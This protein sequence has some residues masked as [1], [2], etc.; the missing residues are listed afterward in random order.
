MYLIFLNINI[1][2]HYT[3]FLF[4]L[5]PHSTRGHNSQPLISDLRK[6]P[7]NS[8]FL[9]GNTQPW[10]QQVM[11]I[12]RSGSQPYWIDVAI[13]V[14][15]IRHTDS[16]GHCSEEVTILHH[17]HRACKWHHSKLWLPASQVI[18]T[19]RKPFYVLLCC[20]DFSWTWCCL[21]SI[22]CAISM[23]M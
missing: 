10:V 12:Q 5:I 14:R 2:F 19:Q 15:V 6:R 9:L 11:S 17:P 20:L 1:T 7:L 8:E 4:I 16:T 18:D 22:K 21:L 23:S 13:S 3:S